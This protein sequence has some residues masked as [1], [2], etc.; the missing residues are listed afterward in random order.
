[1]ITS[2]C[3]LFER[4]S[5]L[6]IIEGVAWDLL[7]TYIGIFSFVMK[8]DFGWTDIFSHAKKDWV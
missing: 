3:M 7:C 6:G 8:I 4:F 1:M 5:V 2:I